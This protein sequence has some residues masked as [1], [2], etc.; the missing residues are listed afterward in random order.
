MVIIAKNCKSIW[1]LLAFALVCGL[2]L[3]GASSSTTTAA[4]NSHITG[5]L[6]NKNTYRIGNEGLVKNLFTLDDLDFDKKSNLTCN[7][8]TQSEADG[9][10][11]EVSVDL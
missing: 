10:I 5:S 9:P 11:Q 3:L 6:N 8:Y 1:K 7:K 4:G 2:L